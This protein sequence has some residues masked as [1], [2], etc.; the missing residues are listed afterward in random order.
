MEDWKVWANYYDKTYPSNF[1]KSCEY[2][3]KL[4]ETKVIKNIVIDKPPL[5]K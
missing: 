4:Q 5:K 3:R 1:V 2:S